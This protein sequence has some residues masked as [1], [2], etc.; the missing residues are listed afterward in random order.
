MGPPAPEQAGESAHQQA[1]VATLSQHALSGT[2]ASSLM[3]EAVAAIAEALKVPYCSILE[4]IPGT[5]DLRVSAGVARKGAPRKST[6]ISG[7][8]ASQAGHTITSGQPVV[9]E[10][11]RK[12][13][14]FK[15]AP[16]HDANLVVSGMT[17]PIPGREAP[18]GVLAVGSLARRVFVVEEVGFLLA[19]SSVLAAAVDRHKAEMTLKETNQQLQALVHA[20]PLAVIALDPS[21][22]VRSWN[23]TA[24]R[25]FGWTAAE[26]FGQPD[27]ILAQSPREEIFKLLDR[28]LHGEASTDVVTQVAKK[29]GTPLEVMVSVGPILGGDGAVGGLIAVIADVTERRRAEAARAQ[30]TE[31]IET[32]TD[33]VIITN[34]PGR[35]FFVNRAGRL[36]LGMGMDEDVSGI[37]LPDLYPGESRGFIVNE[38]IPAAVRDG[39]WSGET[40]LVNRDGREVP[41]S[42]VMI[43]HK[44]PDDEIEFFSIIARDISE[45][46]RLETTLVRQATQDPLTDLNNRRRLEEELNLSL[47]ESRRYG[48]H[49]A[50]MFLDLDQFKQINDSLGHLAGDQLL[51]RVAKLLRERLR[52]TDVL[53]RLG[54]DEFAVLLPHTNADQAQAVAGKILEALQNTA[55]AAKGHTTG[56]TASIGI[57]LFPEHGVTAAD[58]LA[59]ADLAMYQSK[60]GGRNRVNLYKPDRQAATVSRT[61]WQRRI[62]Q[63]LEE[64]LFV[65][66]AQPILDLRDRRIS[67]YELLLRMLGEGGKIIP[68]GVFLDTAERL[69]LIH[70]ID[71]WVARQAIRLLG[72]HK[73]KGRTLTLVTNVSA[74]TLEDPEIVPMIKRELEACAVNPGCLGMEMSEASAISN[75]DKAA[76][77]AAAL[78]QLGCRVGL[79]D[80]G[81]GFASFH[82]LKHLP[83]DY[84]KIDGSFIRDLPNDTTNQQ[85]VRAMVEVA[86]A[87]GKQTIAKFVSDAET[88][89]LLQAFGVDFAQGFH[90]GAE[91]KEITSLSLDRPPAGATRAG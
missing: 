84:L 58:L 17:V 68:P 38:V 47:A 71:R 2:D 56:V 60:E 22:F 76:K 19:V 31:I 11:Y 83:V 7:D 5:Q 48:V 13:T 49:G 12:E 27:P 79:D 32:T 44:G 73:K 82:R 28:A 40:I 4:R 59:R 85:L 35:G 29:D 24:E 52:E 53:A 46:K 77:F 51:V 9:V 57:A 33:C 69:G 10:D 26:V 90:I 20:S 81:V 23:P 3:N 30:L 61:D 1:V 54:G 36:M 62:Q 42:M 66:T 16:F 75:I 14:R 21:G 41:V 43:A 15:T 55:V 88:L 34:I 50:L 89:Q 72:A 86:R 80:F 64:D 74:R 37:A 39:G 70:G 65:L 25:I 91:A 87:F 8:P 6:A 18:L 45:Q 63:A 78:K 67:Q